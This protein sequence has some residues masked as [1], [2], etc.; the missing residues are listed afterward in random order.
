MGDWREIERVGN[1]KGGGMK[2]IINNESKLS[3]PAMMY[4]VLEVMHLGLIS[5]TGGGDCYCRASTFYN[6]KVTADLTKSGTH[7][8]NVLDL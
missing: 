7:V 6:C 3:T 8:F 5:K 4:K 1:S 2:I